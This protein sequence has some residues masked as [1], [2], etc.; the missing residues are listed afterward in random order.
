MPRERLRLPQQR[1]KARWYPPQWPASL[2]Y[3]HIQGQGAGGPGGSGAV[4]RPLRSRLDRAIRLVPSRSTADVGDEADLPQAD[5][6]K[7]WSRTGA[8]AMDRLVSNPNAEP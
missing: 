8:T 6:A 7:G 1:E 3:A 5:Q 4:S 2:Q